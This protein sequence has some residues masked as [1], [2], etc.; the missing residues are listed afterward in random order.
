MK[1]SPAKYYILSAV[2][3]IVAIALGLTADW[4]PLFDNVAPFAFFALLISAGSFLR[5][6]IGG[7]NIMAL[8]DAIGFAALLTYGPAFAASIFLVGM[9]IQIVFTGDAV[10]RRLVLTSVGVIDF[11]VASLVYYD[12]FGAL[13]G[14]AGGARDI[15]AAFSAGLIVWMVDRVCSYATLSFAGVRKM[16]GLFKQL[17]PYLFSVPP[18]YIWGMVGSYIFANSGYLMTSVFVLL[19]LV[20]FVFMRNQKKYLDTVRDMVFS[21]AK[22]I[23]ARDSYTAK[24]S[25]E[26]AVNTLKIAEK[27]GFLEEDAQAIY[28]AA[29][30]HDIG[31]VGIRDSIL[32]KESSLDEGEW[33]IM[34]QHPVIGAEL[35]ASLRFLPGYDKGIRHHHERWDGKGYPDNI[36]G[37]EIPLWARIIAI[38]D[39]WDAMRTDRPYRKA[40]PVEVALDQIKKGCGT[41]FDPNIVPIALE[42][43]QAQADRSAVGSPE[44]VLSR[45]IIRHQA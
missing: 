22:M 3:F 7:N 25:H 33:H 15:V 4:E 12:L 24:H 44:A 5:I 39:A 11:F 45:N 40:L 32:L 42:V 43:F 1:S 27:L 13:P 18:L 21:M 34:R 20:V 30:L 17:K 37:E 23:D 26:V 31:K 9:V 2:F 14:L 35:V 6:D 41:Q 36:A 38:C 8:N 19:L 29:L 28:E 10:F 16:R